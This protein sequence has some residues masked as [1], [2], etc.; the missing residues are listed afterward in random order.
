MDK[1]IKNNHSLLE[2]AR[3]LRRN[4]TRH[5][6]RLWY[7]FLRYYPIKIYKQ[8]TIDNYIV[9]FYCAKA[10]LVIEL[11]GSQH[12]TLDGKLYDTIRSDIIE[13]Y[14]LKVIRFTNL[15]I[16]RRFNKVCYQIDQMIRNTI[17]EE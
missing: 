13:S 5:E 7:E 14:G 11:D 16:D 3:Q 6:K 1:P 4:M 2:N 8:R 12:Y 15:D 9:D 10:R 17:G